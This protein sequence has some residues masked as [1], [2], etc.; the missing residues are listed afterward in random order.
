MRLLFRL[1]LLG[2]AAYGAKTLYDRFQPALEAW[3][4]GGTPAAPVAP[5]PA[6]PTATTPQPTA[7]VA[8]PVAG[9]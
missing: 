2:L 5:A 1:V 6:V 8:T 7:P 9:A 3:R 4:A